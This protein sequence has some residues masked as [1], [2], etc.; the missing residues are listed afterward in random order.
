MALKKTSK[1]RSRRTMRKRGQRKGKLRISKTLKAYITKA[2]KVSTELK[3][4]VPLSFNNQN[5]QAYGVTPNGPHQCTTINLT[6]VLNITQGTDNG[7]RIGD[8]IR[9]KSL[10]FKG[11]VNLNSALANEPDYLKNPMYVKMFVGRRVDTIEDP[12]TY[13]TGGGIGFNNLFQNGP[14]ASGPLNYPSD[15]Y[16][17]V[18]KDVYRIYT[19]RFFKIGMSA[20]SNNPADSNQWNNDFKFAKHFSISLSKHIETVK[21]FDGA[22]KPSNVG[23]YAWFVPVWAN[24]APVTGLARMPLEYHCDVNCTYYDA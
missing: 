24:G 21:Y 16:R 13:A 5:I 18:N 2:I 14:T 11:Y 23:L 10:T 4:A 7:M 12:N 17:Y 15:M 3:H 19:T 8:K 22:T 6:D 20:P 9:V 1:I